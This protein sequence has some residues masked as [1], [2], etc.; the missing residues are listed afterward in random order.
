MIVIRFTLLKC[1]ARCWRKCLTGLSWCCIF[2]ALPVACTYLGSNVL[3][4][5]RSTN[6]FIVLYLVCIPSLTTLLSSCLS[7]WWVIGIRICGCFS[8][9]IH[10]T[11]FVFSVETQVIPF[12]SSDFVYLAGNMWRGLKVELF[13]HESLFLFFL[14]VD[15]F[16]FLHLGE[17]FETIMWSCSPRGHVWFTGPQF[18]T[19]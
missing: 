8:G 12:L 14:A 17:T 4:Q 18:L 5:M 11:A 7:G 15:V 2:I 9:G 10:S 6:C 3:K 1:A 19:V 13:S 16:Q